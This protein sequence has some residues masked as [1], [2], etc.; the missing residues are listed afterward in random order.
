MKKQKNKE[1]KII[2]KRKEVNEFLNEQN[3]IHEKK[4]KNI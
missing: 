1:K 2:K 3:K 4:E